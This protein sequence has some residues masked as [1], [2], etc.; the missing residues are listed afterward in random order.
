MRAVGYAIEGGDHREET[1]SLR[2]LARAVMLGP[3]PVEEGIMRCRMQLEMAGD[4]QI[5][6]AGASLILGAFLAMQGEIDEGRRLVRSARATFEELGLSFRL[7]QSAFV[8]GRLE[9]LAGNPVAAEREFRDGYEQLERLGERSYYLPLFASLLADALAAQGRWE[10]ALTLSESAE[11]AAAPGDVYAQLL[12]RSARARALGGLGRLD[13]AEAVAREAVALAAGSDFF[14]DHGN[15]LASLAEVLAA[16]GRFEDAR[17]ATAEAIE[18][19]E[20]KGA[21][22]AADAARERLAALVE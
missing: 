5:A 10:E 13:E 2:W 21:L 12:W 18:L 17:H 16:Q 7:A 1:E 4:R 8:G 6:R 15:A 14:A 22:A 19:Y 3:T 9:M 11:A 20:R